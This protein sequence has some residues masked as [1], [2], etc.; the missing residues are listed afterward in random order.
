MFILGYLTKSEFE[1]FIPRATAK[2]L[3]LQ[4]FNTV[5]A[6]PRARF[7]AESSAVLAKYKVAQTGGIGEKAI[8]FLSLILSYA[9]ITKAT[10]DKILAEANRP[11][12]LTIPSIGLNTQT[13]LIAVKNA[14]LAGA[15]A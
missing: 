1:W 2:T 4:D 11:N 14:L 8:L 6:N 10:S 3:T 5:Y 12:L 7:I 13:A 15:G 9:P